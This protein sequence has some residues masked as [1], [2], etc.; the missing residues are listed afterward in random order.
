MS[1][2]ELVRAVVDAYVDRAPT[3]HLNTER[4]TR[5]RVALPHDAAD[6]WYPCAG[7]AATANYQAARYEAAAG[8]TARRSGTSAWEMPGTWPPVRAVGG[9]GAPTAMASGRRFAAFSEEVGPLG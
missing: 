6:A 2:G 8:T 5:L 4:I 3:G 1:L 9:A 7:C